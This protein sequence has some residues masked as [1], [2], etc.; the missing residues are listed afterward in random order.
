ML[1]IIF[2]AISLS[3]DAFAVTISNAL[4]YKNDKNLKFTPFYFGIFQGLMPLIGYFLGSTISENISS[5]SNVI[6]FILLS[7]I[8]IKMV[9]DGI[10]TKEDTTSLR[11]THKILFFEAIATSIDALAV[12]ISFSLMSVNI[13]FTSLIIS[14]IT[15]F[16]CFAGLNVFSKIPQKFTHRFEILGGIILVLV[17]IKSLVF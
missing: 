15:V 5:I 7:F 3:A 9:C 2:I 8:G 14:L 6:I 10:F 13:Y 1:E 4:A 12:G 17:G 11:L 16:I